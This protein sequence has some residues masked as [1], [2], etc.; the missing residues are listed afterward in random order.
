VKHDQPVWR[1]GCL[2]LGCG[3]L[4]VSSFRWTV[5]A[6]AWLAP[7]LLMRFVRGTEK[8]ATTLWAI[9]LVSAARFLTIRGGWDMDLWM[10]IVFSV[11]LN[12]PLLAALYMDRWGHRRLPG[13]AATLLF[14]SV[15]TALDWAIAF[16]PVGALFSPAAAQFPYKGILQL[17]GV[18]GIWGIGFLIA[19]LA[20]V[21]NSLWEN[22]RA[23]CPAWVYGLCL[24]LIVLGGGLAFAVDAPDSPT[25]RV[26]GINE[27]HPRDYWS[28]TDAGTP[29]EQVDALRQEMARV[30]D[31]LFAKSERAASLGAKIIF[32]TEG[33]APM[34]ADE[35]DAFLYQAKEFADAH[36]VWLA[37]GVVVL[38]PGEYKNDNLALMVSPDRELVYRYE[39]THSWYPTD[40]DG[41][42]PV[43]ETPWGRVSTVICFDLDF[44]SFVRQAGQ[45]GAD[46]LLVPGYD[47]RA[48]S[49]FHTQA[50]LIRGVEN[51]C[52]VVR[53]AN[54]STS[55]AADWRG[56]VI[57]WQDTFTTADQV[58]VADVP[59]Q[60]R[61]TLYAALGDLF[62][63]ADLA[64]MGALL[65]WALGKGK[66]NRK[67]NEETQ[68]AWGEAE[69]ATS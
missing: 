1:W 14:P 24:L 50:G 6:A 33:A 16:L 65:S 18:V 44:P 8:G 11:A 34:A 25:V 12:A 39:K 38:R 68:E 13:L 3:L 48:I 60:G 20:P 5:P 66:R 7:V 28:V 36:D 41:V 43:A 30:R 57:G 54:D 69:R 15:Y 46:I 55:I 52:S 4:A 29:P 62:V 32:W 67:E 63:Y 37:P 58:M 9:P 17:A 21:V 56:N 53:M 59:S 31:A 61:R 45:A 47:T 51:G 23:A 2:I 27:P 64:L 49:P 19:W 42:V 35:W 26:A 10:E 22:R 40:S